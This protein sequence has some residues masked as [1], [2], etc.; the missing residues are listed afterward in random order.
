ML[1]GYNFHDLQLFSRFWYVSY[2]SFLVLAQIHR[3]LP[4]VRIIVSHATL[5][6]RSSAS[7]DNRVSGI[8]FVE[9]RSWRT[10]V[11]ALYAAA[12]LKIYLRAPITR[13]HVLE[14]LS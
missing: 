2:H 11:V 7:V 13:N 14:G 5:T 10:R 12:Q 4:L 3:I 9:R 1:Q 6:E 8:G